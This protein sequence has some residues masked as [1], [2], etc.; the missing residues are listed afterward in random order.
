MKSPCEKI[1]QEL[2]PSIRSEIVRELAG[3]GLKNAD[4]ARKLGITR[5]S[6][7]L[8]LKK[9]RGAKSLDKKMKIAVKKIAKQLAK[10]NKKIEACTIC[11][12]ISGKKCGWSK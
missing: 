10:E 7:G 2:L 12:A 6:V 5:S 3:G 11:R 1:V 4:I 9:R 8:Y